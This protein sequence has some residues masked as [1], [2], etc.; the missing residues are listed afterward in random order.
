MGRNISNSTSYTGQKI[1]QRMPQPGEIWEVNRSIH[2]PVE[3]SQEQQYQLYS[4]AARQFMRG[5]YPPMNVMIVTKEDSGVFSQEWQL[6]TV[7][8]LSGETQFLS[9]VDLLIPSDIS[10][11]E[12]DVLAQTWLVEEMFACNLV[13]PVGKRLSRNIYDLLLSVGDFDRQIVAQPPE[14]SEIEL[15]GLKIG[16]K[17]AIEDLRIMDF[18]RHKLACSDVLSIPVAAYRTY[19]DSLNFTEAV[20]E[21]ALEV[22]KDLLVDAKKKES[23]VNVLSQWLQNTF[24]AQWQLLWQTPSLAIATR[25]K[26]D[27]KP[28]GDEI[29]ALIKQVFSP[30]EHYR[31]KAA[32]KLG[33][34]ALGNADGIEALVNLIRTTQNDETLWVAVES[35]WKINP[36]NPAAGVRKVK[37]LDLGMQLAG[38]AVALAVALVPKAD[39]KIGVLLQAYST[40]TETDDSD[41][42]K[43]LLYLPPGLKLILLSE[44]GETLR[45]VT[46]RNADIYV[47][48][49]FSG[50]KSEQF[51]VR[52]ALNEASITEDFEI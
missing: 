34:I 14:K 6:I 30:D 42:S 7:M 10:G 37:L 16:T 27:S 45:E 41:N 39:G 8:M 13:K 44:T 11:L 25:S 33:E 18:H 21:E 28:D 24:D 23:K 51:S 46:A 40:D 9:D 2:S 12:K 32:K 1:I 52:V 43:P 15:A 47:Q 49:K 3:F 35:L 48:L 38:E 29:A 5:I 26:F 31:R 50:E 4:D 36:G 20:L 22:D 19:L 17:K